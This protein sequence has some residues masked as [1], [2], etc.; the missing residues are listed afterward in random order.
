MPVPGWT[1]TVVVYDNDLE[2]GWSRD[3]ENNSNIGDTKIFV[4]L[5]TIGVAVSSPLGVPLSLLL[6]LRRARLQRR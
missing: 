2:Y 4:L 1:S 6:Y 5:M 3:R